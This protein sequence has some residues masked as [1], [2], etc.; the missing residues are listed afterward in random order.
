[1]NKPESTTATFSPATASSPD[2]SH[3]DASQLSALQPAAF[4]AA[5]SRRAA[6]DPA[7]GRFGPGQSRSPCSRGGQRPGTGRYAR[8]D[9]G[10]GLSVHGRSGKYWSNAIENS[11]PLI[12]CANAASTLPWFR[13]RNEGAA[14]LPGAPVT[15]PDRQGPSSWPRNRRSL[16]AALFV[17]TCAAGALPATFFATTAAAQQTQ[18]PVVAIADQSGVN[19]NTATAEELAETLNGVGA[20]KADAIVR[21]RTQFG[22]F[23]SIEELTEVKGIGAATIERNRNLLR[24]ED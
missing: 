5:G 4:K 24:L 17:L 16:S 3:A 8:G 9:S 18:T 20:G 21:Y 13:R 12:S 10:T 15:S 1:M 19:I 2:S 11:R 23:G 14:R 6:A 7:A 22:P